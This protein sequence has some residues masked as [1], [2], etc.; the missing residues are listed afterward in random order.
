M[1]QY[2]LMPRRSTPRRAVAA[3]ALFAILAV[4]RVA[5]AQ[6]PNAEPKEEDRWAAAAEFSMTAT[7]GNQEVTVL[8]TGFSLRHLRHELFD[9]Q[10]KLEA[11]YGSSNGERVVENYQGTFNFDI[12]P[13]HRWSPFLYGTAEHDPFKRLDVRVNSGAG[14]KYRV[15]RADNRGEASLSLAVLHSYE[16]LTTAGL[17][18]TTSARWSLRL[19]GRQQIRDGVMLSSEALYEPVY[20]DVSDYL[21]AL[22]AGLKVLVTQQIALS[23]T[24][25]Y[26]Q[27]STPAEGVGEIDR[28]LRAGIL[29][30]L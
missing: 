8:A 26:N 13:N 24:H 18:P 22:D 19:T 21:L 5:L 15:Y 23:V 1:Q 30:E 20:N 27:D 7:S 10:L 2:F 9:L 11:S 16:A 3:A 4:A 29:I 28:L 6:G 17:E 25:E 12:G 14:A